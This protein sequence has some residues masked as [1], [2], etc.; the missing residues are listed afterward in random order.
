MSMKEREQRY[1]ARS[2]V[3]NGIIID[4]LNDQELSNFE[5]LNTNSGTMDGSSHL[6]KEYPKRY[7]EAF[8]FRNMTVTF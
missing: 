2:C 4:N 1:S 6:V 5:C 3:N 8:D 7:T